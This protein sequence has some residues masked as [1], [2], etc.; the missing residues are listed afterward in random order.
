[1]CVCVCVCVSVCVCVC[2]CVSVCVCVCFSFPVSVCVTLTLTNFCFSPTAP[3]QPT[4]SISHFCDQFRPIRFDRIRAGCEGWGSRPA[5]LIPCSLLSICELSL[6]RQQPSTI[7]G[8]CP[9][10]MSPSK[11]L[12]PVLPAGEETKCR[13]VKERVE[14]FLLAAKCGRDTPGRSV[15]LPSEGH[16]KPVAR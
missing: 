4:I 9:S 7:P 11:P 13:A 15:G 16:R 2:V 14:D 5:L 6:P 10:S 1:V 3:Q 8:G 12:P